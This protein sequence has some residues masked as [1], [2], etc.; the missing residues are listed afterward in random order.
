MPP[1]KISRASFDALPP[2]TAQQSQQGAMSGDEGDSGLLSQLPGMIGD[3][4][5]GAAKGV[6]DTSTSLVGMVP[7][8]NSITDALGN[9]LGGQYAKYA[10]G[11]ESVSPP[12]SH[13]QVEDAFDPTNGAQQVGKTAEQ[14]GEFFV[15]AGPARKAAVEGLVRYGIPNSASPST[16]KMLNKIMAVAGRS[17][18]EGASA[19]AVGKLH[20]EE[21]VDDTALIAALGPLFNSAAT[22]AMTPLVKKAMATA[23][24]GVPQGMMGGGLGS[25]MG[26]FG[27]IRNTIEEIL[28]SKAAQ[29]V[30]STASKYAGRAA[31]AVNSETDN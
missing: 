8:V 16:M 3:V 24:A 9:F 31:A 12:V 4:A 21:N 30:G 18:G 22:S 28:N 14:I 25:R 7:G 15:P 20:G 13:H 17:V 10:H 2:V 29:K 11:E 1:Q 23:M 27:I 26:M 6:G 19:A 5:M